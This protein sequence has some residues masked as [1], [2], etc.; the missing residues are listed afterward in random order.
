M[1]PR[2]AAP[3]SH[4]EL[5]PGSDLTA[6]EWE[7]ARAIERYRARRKKRFLSWSEVLTVARELGYRRVPPGTRGEPADAGPPERAV[8]A[9]DPPGE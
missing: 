4:Q 5:F 3:G 2:R 8:S 9:R 7:F 6:E 1:S